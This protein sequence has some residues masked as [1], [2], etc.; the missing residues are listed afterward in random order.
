MEPCENEKC[1]SCCIDE[2]DGYANGCCEFTTDNLPLICR[3]YLTTKEAVSNS[4]SVAGLK[5]CPSC[6][7][8]NLSRRIPSPFVLPKH[9]V[10][11]CR[12]CG[13]MMT[14]CMNQEESDMR[15]NRRTT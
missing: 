14:T 13:M 8:D 3:F 9:Y 10:V 2:S 4:D 15:W 11:H 6:N 1:K 5:P 7:G 12:G